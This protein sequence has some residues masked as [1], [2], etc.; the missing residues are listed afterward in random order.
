VQGRIIKSID[1]PL[2]DNI[3]SNIMYDKIVKAITKLQ[4]FALTKEQHDNIDIILS[5][6][7]KNGVKRKRQIAYIFATVFHESARKEILN[8]KKVYRRI[9][10]IEEIGRGKGKRYGKKIKYN[11]TSYTLPN[12]LYYGR[13][14]VQLTWYELYQT[15]SKVLKIDLLNNP[16]LALDPI[17]SADIAVIGMMKGLFTGV[18]LERYINDTKTDIINARRIINL[19]DCAEIIKGYYD[20]IYEEIK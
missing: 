6:I 12:Q 4:G 16:E 19:L 1:V 17:I 2:A 14:F 20:V 5:A 9:L 10:C 13:G 7:N 15:F 11:G 18:G 3:V 8:G